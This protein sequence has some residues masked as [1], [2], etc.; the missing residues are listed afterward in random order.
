MSLL[1]FLID[2]N[3]YSDL[4]NT[5]NQNLQVLYICNS[6]TIPSLPPPNT[7]IISL[8]LTA[9]CP[10]RGFGLIPPGDSTLHHLDNSESFS[11]DISESSNNFIA[12]HGTNNT[13][14]NKQGVANA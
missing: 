12:N 5:E 9:R 6:S 11:E 3:R 13:N 7:I 14:T 8:T 2:R 10:C 1:I 4:R